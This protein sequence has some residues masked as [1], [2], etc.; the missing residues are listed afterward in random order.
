MIRIYQLCWAP[1]CRFARHILT[2]ACAVGLAAC[3]AP[4]MT[5]PSATSAPTRSAAPLPVAATVETAQVPHEGDAA[6]DSAI[7]VHPSNPALSTV[8]GTDKKGGLAVYDL[9]GQQLQYL[10]DGNMNNVDLRAGFPLGGQA[11]ALVAASNRNNTIAL[12]RVNPTT[13]RLENAAARV[14]ATGAGYGACMY[15][16]PTTGK[17]Y[18]FANSEQGEVEQWE[19]FDDGSGQVDAVKVR[20]FDVGSQTEGCVADD[21]LG[22]L[23][24]GEEAKG[25]WK[26][27]AEPSA[28]DTRTQVD[29]TGSGGQL[30]ADVEGLTIYNA[31]G[32]R[33][34]LIAS[35]Q[36][37]SAYV[38]YRREGANTY[39]ATFEIVAAGRID[40]VSQTDGIAVTSANL[41]PAFSQGLF[42]AQDGKNDDC[43]Q[44]FKFV[45]WQS[46]A[47]AIGQASSSDRHPPAG[48]TH[49]LAGAPREGAHAAATQ[50]DTFLP[51]T[52]IGC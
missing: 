14:I 34:Y 15:H 2:L 5:A 16:S 13:R 51:I 4:D 28:G 33:G 9:A 20:A 35:S 37:D 22:H 31:G 30:K 38:I 25:I 11:V 46:I 12:Y 26:Y 1:A 27:G 50:K 8:I 41:G 19:L 42:I 29:K 49:L 6:D 47:A 52:M 23:Y 48:A 17:F 32:G 24:I 7:W 3:G 39:V 44:N 18:Y 43:N 10:P 40:A 45:P 21:Q 36:G